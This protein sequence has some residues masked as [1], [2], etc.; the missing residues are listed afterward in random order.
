MV[1]IVDTRKL[2]A[3][4]AVAE[5]LHFG[6]AARR[7]HISQPPLSLSI[8]ALEEDLGTKLFL[9]SSRR[10]ELTDA[11]RVLLEQ[12]REILEQLAEARRRTAEAGRG[13]RG[14]LSI[15]FITPVV[16]GLLPGLL[17]EFR[18]RFP[19]VRL[20]LREAMGDAQLEE[21]ES[22]KLSAGFVAA[23]VSSQRLSQLAMLT[24]PM[25]AALPKFH[26]LARR[27]GAIRLAQLAGETFIL[28]PRTVAP[29]LFD[30]I[31][32]FC[33]A[34]GF[35]PRVEQEAMQS[36]TIVGLVS[37]GL[38]V[39]IVPASIKQLRRPGVVYRPFKERSPRVETLL[40]WRSE[41][42]SPALQNF[43]K[44]AEKTAEPG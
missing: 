37:A 22:G 41:D 18:T 12:A 10:V 5:E 7:L 38:G 19:G 30:S 29:G 31:V 36:Q 11:G 9:R 44:M 4:V 33:R 14:S 27:E 32:A 42:R 16:Y 35:S 17:R 1:S 21:L 34:S 26:P 43:V 23:P 28:F 39:A 6:R 24:E 20:T 8:R 2:T 3:F 13:E 15:G 25:V 40:V